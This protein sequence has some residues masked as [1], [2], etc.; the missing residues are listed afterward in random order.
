L[1]SA[2]SDGRTIADERLEALSGM[3]NDVLV[4][5]SY[6]GL[7]D[8]D[9]GGSTE[10]EKA[11]LL[12]AMDHGAGRMVLD[13]PA[14]HGRAHVDVD[15]IAEMFAVQQT[16]VA[17]IVAESRDPGSQGK[18]M[19]GMEDLS[20]ALE[21]SV[22][23]VVEIAETVIITGGEAEDEE[24]SSVVV[25]GNNLGGQEGFQLYGAALHRDDLAAFDL[26]GQESAVGR[27]YQSLRS[28]SDG[29]S[30]LGEGTCEEVVEALE[31]L[32]GPVQFV[33]GNVVHLDETAKAP[34]TAA[35]TLVRAEEAR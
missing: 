12:A 30:A 7:Q 11:L 18:R 6:S 27:G 2:A 33:Q 9:D 4:E 32:Q 1:T 19:D 14:H 10:L 26:V 13:D 34:K 16:E 35:A 20:A 28:S 17:D 22:R 5:D 29:P 24:L 25:L 23:A 31:V 21:G 8:E 3:G 15:D